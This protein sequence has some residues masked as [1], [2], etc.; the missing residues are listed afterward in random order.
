M[1]TSVVLL[2]PQL[3]RHDTI[4]VII[5]AMKD[6]QSPYLRNMVYYLLCYPL[7]PLCRTYGLHKISPVLS[8]L[9]FPCCCV[10]CQPSSLQ[11]PLSWALLAAVSNVSPAAFSSLS[12]GLSLLLCP[13]SAQQPS[14]PSLLGSHC[15]CVQCQPSSLQFPLSWALLAAVPHA[16]PAAFSSLCLGL[17]LLRCPMSAQQPSV[18]P[19]FASM[20]FLGCPV[21][22]SLLGSTSTLF[23][24]AG[25]WSLKTCPSHFHLLLFRIMQMISCFVVWFNLVFLE[26][27]SGQSTCSIFLVQVLWKLTSKLVPCCAMRQHSMIEEHE[28]TLAVVPNLNHT[29]RDGSTIS[30]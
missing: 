16:W 3:T 6:T 1:S 13:M 21:S 20:L 24:L 27:V 28:R 17:S 12:L 5:R 8:I 2:C 29:A 9:D 7:L 14:V 30:G 23:S 25:L 26:M 10:Q 22:S 15:C 18:P 4:K 11:F 19:W